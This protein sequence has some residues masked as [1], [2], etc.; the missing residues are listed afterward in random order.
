MLLE[1]PPGSNRLM[2]PRDVANELG[3]TT[4]NKDCKNIIQILKESYGMTRIEGVGTRIPRRN[5]EKFL[6]DH[7]GLHTN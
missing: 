3:M 5:F 2:R 7:Y 4:T 1:T 6:S